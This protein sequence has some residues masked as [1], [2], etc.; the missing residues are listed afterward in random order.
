MHRVLSLNHL[1]SI[2]DWNPDLNHSILTCIFILYM[3]KDIFEVNEEL[4][5]LQQIVWC[6]AWISMLNELL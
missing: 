1:I 3:Y 6:R 2:I 4:Q 5:K